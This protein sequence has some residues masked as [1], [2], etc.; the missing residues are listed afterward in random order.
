[1]HE[2]I[3]KNSDGEDIGIPLELEYTYF[4]L[5]VRSR[6]IS[7]LFN[8]PTC[9]IFRRDPA[10]FEYVLDKLDD[11]IK[12]VNTF[13]LDFFRNEEGTVK[14]DNYTLH[15][16]LKSQ[17]IDPLLE[18]IKKSV[19]FTEDVN[20]LTRRFPTRKAL[21]QWLLEKTLPN[22]F[23]KGAELTTTR[24]QIVKILLPFTTKYPI[25]RGG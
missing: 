1:M 13:N 12:E 23:I 14:V 5:L 8:G 15:P 25:A 7:L 16:A 20:A 24:K 21:S 4:N 22:N 17:I 6:L 18:T 19:T 11:F 10:P 2:D 3:F 9:K